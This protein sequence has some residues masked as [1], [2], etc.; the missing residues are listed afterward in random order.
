MSKRFDQ[1][2]GADFVRE[3]PAEPAVYLFKDGDGTV[4]Y[5]G[6][7]KNIRRRLQSY[8]RAGRRKAHRKMARLVR[9]ARS[10]EV[11]LQDSEKA[12]LLLENELIR[13]LRPRFNVEGAYSFLY[14]AIG[15]AHEHGQTLLAFTT[16]VGLY[17]GFGF[18][19]HGTFRSRLRGREAFEALLLLLER[20]G[21][22]ERPARARDLPRRRGSSVLA[23]RRIEQRVPSLE[24]F[25]AGENPELLRE[26]AADLLEKP[27]AR[28]AREA[29]GDALRLLL[30]FFDSDARPLREALKAR[31][32]RGTFVSQQQRDALFIEHGARE[33][34]SSSA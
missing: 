10:I 29:V 19:W 20:A 22:R 12:A 30:A 7:A 15:V 27:D 1:K 9:E 34:R 23:F 24:R 18:R 5:A 3:L 13:T 14:P 6:K 32:H 4:I 25:L 8:R 26:L 33:D 2:F 16:D 21:H 17:E 28:E 11:R 31:G